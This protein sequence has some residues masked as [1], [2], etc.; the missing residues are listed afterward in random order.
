MLRKIRRTEIVENHE[1]HTQKKYAQI[2]YG[3]IAE[4]FSGVSSKIRTGRAMIMPATSS[5]APKTMERHTDGTDGVAD[6]LHV[7][8]A[9]IIGDDHVGTNG[10]PDKTIRPS[11]R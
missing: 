11:A 8:L 10:N 6:T 4:I 5:T 7:F 1:R 3:H 9:D 2:Q